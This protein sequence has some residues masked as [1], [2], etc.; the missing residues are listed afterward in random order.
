[1]D[2][3]TWT[4]RGLIAVL[5]T[6]LS[7]LFLRVR[8]NETRLAVIEARLEKTDGVPDTLKDVEITLARLDERMVHLPKSRDLQLI[9]DRISKNAETGNRTKESV[10]ALNESVK[11]LRSAVDRLHRVADGPNA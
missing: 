9:H 4:V 8:T 11:G 10:I 2:V 3:E 1:M 7:G 5:I 6:A